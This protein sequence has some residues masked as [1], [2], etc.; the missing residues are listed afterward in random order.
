MKK[1]VYYVVDN[2][3]EGTGKDRILY[4]SFDENELDQKLSKDPSKNWRTKK[5]KILDEGPATAQA[6]SKLNGIE[7]LL[8][9]LPAWPAKSV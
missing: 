1:I 8:L 7:R 6:L 2:G 4:A 3:I 5:E 9:G